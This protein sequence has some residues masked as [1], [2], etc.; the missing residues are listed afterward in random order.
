MH[1]KQSNDNNNNI[2][3]QNNYSA[4]NMIKNNVYKFKKKK[5]LK[6]LDLMGKSTGD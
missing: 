6:S 5:K 2:P 4:E 1:S 3:S